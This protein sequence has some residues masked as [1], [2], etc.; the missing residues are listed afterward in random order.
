MKKHILRR[1]G[2]LVLALVLA[3]TLT[4]PAL[5]ADATGI[6]LNKNELRLTVGGSERLTST[7]TYSDGTQAAGTKDTVSWSSSDPKVAAVDAQSGTVTA[8]SAGTA[9]ITATTV[10]GGKTDICKVTVTAKAASSLTITGRDPLIVEPS[11]KVT[12]TAILTN[13]SDGN[14]K[15]SWSIEPK[16]GQT[17]TTPPKLTENP[18]EL[19]GT[20][21][22]ATATFTPTNANAGDYIVTAKYGDLT[23]TKNVTVSG[24][25]LSEHSKEMYVNGSGTLTVAIYGNADDRNVTHVE[26]NSSDSSIVSVMLDAGSLS[27]WKLGT[28]TIKAT[29]GKYW[30]ECTVKVVEDDSVIASGYTASASN[31]LKLSEVY[32]ALEAMAA[33]KEVGELSYIT[34]LSVSTRQGTLYYNYVSEGDTGA[35]VGYSDQ[36]AKTAKGNIKSVDRLYFVP[37]QGFS[38]TAEIT[39]NAIAGS[40]N[41]AGIIRVSVNEDGD[42][43]QI[44]YRTQAGEPV[45]F[46]PDDFNTFCKSVTGR[47][48]N[49]VTF[50]LPQASQGTLYYNYMAGSGT[51][52]TTTTKFTPSGVY[53]IDNVCFVPNAAFTGE[54]TI[55][56]HAED[57][58][59]EAVPGTVK[60]NVTAPSDD[61]DP[62]HVYF[63]GEQGQPV[64][65]KAEPFNAASQ[66]IIND[67]LSFVIFKQLP[68]PSQGVL[69]YN[70]QGS[71]NYESRVN[72]TTRYN[73]SGVPGLNGV[74]FV[75]SSN[76]AG[77]IAIS[78]TGY[79]SRGS[80]F[81]GM[82]YITLGE[83]D[84][85]TIRYYV[86]KGGAVSFS[87]SDFYA[88]GSYRTGLALDYVVFDVAN[89]VQ[90]PNTDLGTL[91]E[92]WSSTTKREVGSS[93]YY[94][95]SSYQRLISE[96]SYHA[97]DKTG[98]VTIPYTAYC[99]T[100]AGQQ[101][102]TGNVV[103]QVGFLPP[104]DVNLYCYTSGEAWLSSSYLSSVCGA[105]MSS[106][107]S[108]IEITGIPAAE[109][110][111]LY[112]NYSGFGTGTV[113]EKGNRFYCSGSPNISQLSFIPRAGFTG[114]VEITYIGY[115]SD[116]SEQVSGRVLVHVAQS[117]NSQFFNDMGNHVWAIDSVDYLYGNRTVNGVGGSRFNP[118]GT[119]TRGDFA[120][121][122]VRAY[123][124]TA[125]GNASFSDVPAGSY[126]AD[127]IR[128]AALLGIVNGSNGRFYPKN[129]LSRQDAVVMIYNALKAS[130]KT[131]SNGL[132]AD[133]SRYHDESA[134]AP[135]A[136]EAM[137]SLVQMG[138]VNGVGNGYLQPQ[139]QLN[140]AEAAK[141]LHTI[142]TL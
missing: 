134:I 91:Y 43:Y 113:V 95:S 112:L 59:G 73:F 121:M 72:T 55:S 139:R 108:S 78:Y 62:S 44:S 127:A 51:L 50:N 87:A 2:A 116:G 47:G 80:S 90:V 105:V 46:L 4:V 13:V 28:V 10:K 14:A 129:A 133:L 119:I 60:V 130:G 48:F 40:G 81:S 84:R 75:P 31:P 61:G 52:V 20:T 36:F 7:I 70:Y 35:G 57:T 23:A 66:A 24:I 107:L 58:S 76:A 71:G 99:G 142:M 6:A 21:F 26:W 41:F 15:I 86:A 126:Y 34:N 122:L 132:A 106:S 19:S 25:V 118:T 83:A 17:N 140:R 18:G 117:R 111:H 114:E 104:D 37:K 98:T 125:S 9:T 5:A 79:G 92:Y 110:G 65:L 109:A 38:G 77:R 8:V 94:Y 137:G 39:F 101:S 56:F 32:P 138:V 1:T 16:A 3:L 67:T 131:T 89:A 49:S 123:H 85:T 30:D 141:L 27:A 54:A 29:K 136:R 45:W 68:D 74:T 22:T 102:F 11:D 33:E 124:F 97:L 63:S 128:V 115:N 93:R 120:L 88:A 53:T 103:I 12:L 42:E 64:T 135:Y 82:L 100:G 96:V 69:Y